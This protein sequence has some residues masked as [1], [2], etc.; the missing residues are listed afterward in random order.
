LDPA[1]APVFLPIRELIPEDAV[2][3]LEKLAVA[4]VKVPFTSNVV[5]GLNVPIPTFPFE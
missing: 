1:V 4:P 3:K 5:K 2:T